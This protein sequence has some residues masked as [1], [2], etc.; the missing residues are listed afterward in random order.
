M[1]VN[2]FK[3]LVKHVYL[4]GVEEYVRQPTTTNPERLAVYRLFHLY[5]DIIS[6]EPMSERAFFD[7][8]MRLFHQSRVIYG[9]RMWFI[10]STYYQMA[11]DYLQDLQTLLA[12][13][14]SQRTQEPCESVA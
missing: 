2:Q 7:S 13:Y 11:H 3:D 8:V 12:I 9:S 6:Q 4:T 5:N 10:G 14:D 1:T